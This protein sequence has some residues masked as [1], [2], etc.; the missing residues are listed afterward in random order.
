[1]FPM[2]I[3][4]WGLSFCLIC[5][6][7]FAL[8]VDVT[9]RV[10]FIFQNIAPNM[11]AYLTNHGEGRYIIYAVVIRSTSKCW[12]LWKMFIVC[13]YKT[14]DTVKKVP[15]FSFLLNDDLGK[16][17]CCLSQWLVVMDVVSYE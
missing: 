5:L 12:R 7:I 11:P 16:P 1:M 3:L 6:A 10:H 2:K 13:A 17:S 14:Q 4:V 8:I 9:Y 15:V